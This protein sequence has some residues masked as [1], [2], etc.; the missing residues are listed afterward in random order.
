MEYIYLLDDFEKNRYDRNADI[1]GY[2]YNFLFCKLARL[3]VKKK[4]TK[5]Y[6]P[7]I[8]RNETK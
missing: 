1:I 4:K 5:F 3:Y 8:E 6:G 2:N 7:S